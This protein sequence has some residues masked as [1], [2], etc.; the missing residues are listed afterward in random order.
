MREMQFIVF[1]H[2]IF[3]KKIL[4]QKVADNPHY[5][6]VPLTMCQISNPSTL[7]CCC[8]SFGVQLVDLFCSGIFMV[9][10]HTLGI[11]RYLESSSLIHHRSYPSVVFILC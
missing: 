3:E 8:S 11:S 1:A 4:K 9:L 6:S 5:M 7:G 10:F 2:T